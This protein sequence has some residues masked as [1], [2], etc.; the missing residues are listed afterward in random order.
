MHAETDFVCW[1]S[2]WKGGPIDLELTAV[3]VFLVMGQ[4]L[5]W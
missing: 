4:G 3:A 1:G 2:L 5:S